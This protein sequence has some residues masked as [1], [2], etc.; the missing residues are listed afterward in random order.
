MRAAVGDRV[1]ITSAHTDVPAREGEVVSV[2]EHGEPPWHV[3]WS[4]DEHE[5]TYCPG[6]DTFVEPKK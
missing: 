5:T 2:S 1:V 3:R 4:E 6:P